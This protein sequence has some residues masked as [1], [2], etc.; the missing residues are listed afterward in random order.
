MSVNQ[1]ADPTSTPQSL[2]IHGYVSGRIFKS[3]K[4]TSTPGLPITIAASFLDG[5]VL[6]LTPF[7]N[8]CNYRSAIVY[9]YAELV[10]DAGEALYAMKAITDNMLPERW[11]K[12]RVPPS[13]AELKSTSILRVR[14]ESASAKVRT[15]GPS[16]DRKDLADKELVKKTW[17]GVVPYWG[18]WGEPVPG[19]E[20]GCEDVEGYI[21]SWRMRETAGARGYAFEAIGKG[22]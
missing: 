18:T 2:Y 4:E 7:H 9:G 6:S 3:S 13:S 1:S 5:L 16:E 20:N 17:T 15:G 22:K 19:E 12:S 11:E 10:E 8:S 21:E 14:V